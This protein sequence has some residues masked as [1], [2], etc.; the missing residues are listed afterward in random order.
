MQVYDDF[1]ESLKEMAKRNARFNINEMESAKVIMEAKV[2]K[3]EV[4]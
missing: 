4:E 1:G 3:K 2:M